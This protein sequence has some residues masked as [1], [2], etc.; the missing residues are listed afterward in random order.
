METLR[1]AW[2]TAVS[3]P[4]A[5]SPSSVAS[6]G[7]R[8]ASS[9]LSSACG[10]H[11]VDRGVECGERRRQRPV[12]G[13]R[14]DLG[15]DRVDPLVE[16]LSRVLERVERVAQPLEQSFDRVA[17]LDNV[18]HLGEGRVD[19]RERLV[20]G[21]RL[22]DPLDDAGDHLL[23]RCDQLL[24]AELVEGREQ[25]VEERLERREREPGARLGSQPRLQRSRAP[26]RP[27]RAARSA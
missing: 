6:A 14:L 26:A 4:V 11:A 10:A 23:E 8:P 5:F 12:V 27:A 16:L 18:L 3:R 7:V 2:T 22:D 15:E 25:I 20:D 1:Y 13:E 17:D 19:C 9:R 24:G 21:Q